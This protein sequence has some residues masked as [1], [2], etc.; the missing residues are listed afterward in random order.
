M[1]LE[2]GKVGLGHVANTTGEVNALWVS[3]CPVSI[4]STAGNT[5]CTYDSQ[6]EGNGAVP[7][8]SIR[9]Q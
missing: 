6:V 8:L 7:Q 5:D 9:G 4:L 2:D 3:Q 1:L